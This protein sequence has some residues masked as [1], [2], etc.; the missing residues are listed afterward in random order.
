ML[1]VTGLT[2]EYGD[3]VVCDNIG[4]EANDNRIIGF[5]GPNGAGKSTTMNMI[6]GYISPTKGSILIND[7]SMIQN[8]TKA[9]SFIGYLPEIPP[10]YLDMTVFEYLDFAFDLKKLKS[11]CLKDD[12]IDRVMELTSLFD[13]E[14]RLI[15]TLSKG[16]RQRVGLAQALLGDPEIIIL[17]EPSVGL[18]PAQIA[19]L[20]NVIKNLGKNHIVILSTH[21]LSEVSAVCDDVIIISRGKVCASGSIAELEEK[22]NDCQRLRLVIK[23]SSSGIEKLLS[24]VDSIDTFNVLEETS[25]HCL[26]DI[27]AKLMTDIR[28][29]ISRLCTDNGYTILE[30]SVNHISLEEVYLKLTGEGNNVS[31]L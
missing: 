27:K 29:E 6:T 25:N 5:L 28:E 3:R 23:G 21:I 4:F 14:D 22:Y 11:K 2:K 17:D 10:V 26:I 15:K 12:E 16:Y 7:V 20:R 13:V 24:G 19:E 1:K 9:K 30:L 18:D 31:D 8:P